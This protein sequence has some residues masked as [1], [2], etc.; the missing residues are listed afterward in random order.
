M[1]PLRD[2][3]RTTSI[4]VMDS[5]LLIMSYI[6]VSQTFDEK[7][8]RTQSVLL[9]RSRDIDSVQICQGLIAALESI[10]LT[11]GGV[12]LIKFSHS[13][14]SALNVEN[15]RVELLQP[16]LPCIPTSQLVYHD[17]HIKFFPRD[18]KFIPELKVFVREREPFDC[19]DGIP[20]LQVYE[21]PPQIFL[22]K[23]PPRDV[24][25]LT[26]APF[27]RAGL[28]VVPNI[29]RVASGIAAYGYTY[30]ADVENRT[31][32]VYGYDEPWKRVPDAQE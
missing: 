19:T 9:P 24:Q 17:V 20:Y 5:T 11:C 30:S 18:P 14:L 21:T 10:K 13:M 25:G 16:F 27:K 26:E 4:N 29:L 1:K 3:V 31:R 22:S 23:D 12:P 8:F 28:W 6:C 7:K 32:H 2:G 15:G